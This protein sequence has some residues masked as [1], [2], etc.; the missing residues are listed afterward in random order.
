MSEETISIND[1]IAPP[2]VCCD[3]YLAIYDLVRSDDFNV[4]KFN[5]MLM[6]VSAYLDHHEFE[7]GNAAL[8]WAEDSDSF[9]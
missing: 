4:A 3:T 8:P 1:P 5:A 2:V 7:Y 9:H 6:A